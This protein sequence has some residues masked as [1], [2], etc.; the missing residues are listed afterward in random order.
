VALAEVQ[1]PQPALVA[2]EGLDLD[3]YYL[4]HGVRADLLR[5]LGRTREARGAY[6]VAIAL[7]ANLREREFLERRRHE[8]DNELEDVE[9]GRSPER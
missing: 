7:A 6:D 4:F 3:R 2:I 9:T 1:G 5:K 8:L